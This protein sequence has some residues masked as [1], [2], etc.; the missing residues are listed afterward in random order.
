M[1]QLTPAITYFSTF[2]SSQQDVI[3]A[4]NSINDWYSQMSPSSGYCFTSRNDMSLHSNQRLCP[5]GSNS[6]I[7]QRFQINFREH[8]GQSTWRFAVFMD[9]GLG[10]TASWNN[11]ELTRYAADVW[12]GSSNPIWF[13]LRDV[14]RGVHSLVV[15]GRENC[16]DG[17][18][19][20]WSVERNGQGFNA[21]SVDTLNN[22]GNTLRPGHEMRI[23]PHYDG[24]R[25]WIR[26]TS[27][28]FP[29][30]LASPDHTADWIE[31]RVRAGGIPGSGAFC[32]RQLSNLN[33]YANSRVCSGGT[34]SNF[35]QKFE[36][37]F[38][39]PRGNANWKF[40]M[41][42]DAGLG[43]AIYL[44]RTLR[45]SNHNDLWTNG[46]G[47]ILEFGGVSPGYHTLVVY[48]AENCCDG[49]V[50]EWKFAR[51]NRWWNSLSVDNLHE[52][53]RGESTLSYFSTHLPS[54]IGVDATRNFIESRYEQGR[55]IDW[56]YCTTTRD[57][58]NIHSNQ[59]I[60]GSSRNSNI[61]QR[62]M[63][64][65]Y[66][67]GC[68]WQ[69]RIYVDAGY[70]SSVVLDGEVVYVNGND[71]W[72]PFISIERELARGPHTLIVYGGEGCCDGNA[73]QWIFRSCHENR[74][75]WHWLW[76]R[77][78]VE[79]VWRELSV[80]QLNARQ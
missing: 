31:R 5:G 22:L 29:D 75:N 55:Q 42:L 14:P 30:R 13:I 4:R 76:W 11:N 69:F 24:N 56:G 19:G 48:G 38:Y 12:G 57:N 68:F 34:N 74:V 63:I 78:T 60:C 58:F 21:L 54:N 70:G 44:D 7:A 40:S 26:Y 37:Q 35:G 50:G 16:C 27:V 59:G 25:L 71:I 18:A 10:Y 3:S 8:S 23:P 2:A 43:W 80:G 17:E 41:Q 15:T 73:G 33:L 20:G 79:E 47:R 62:F 36:I 66:S 39:E 32:D 67:S 1:C 52:A 6:N 9:S 46:N 49:Q 65:F 51:N 64:N 45:D 53:S 28:P 77:I 61:G 72:G